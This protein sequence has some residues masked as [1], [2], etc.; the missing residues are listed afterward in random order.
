MCLWGI[1]QSHPAQSR[2]PRYRRN[3]NWA[4][5]ASMGLGSSSVGFQRY[6][7]P[8]TETRLLQN[9]HTDFRAVFSLT[10]LIYCIFRTSVRE[11][12]Y[13][14]KYFLEWMYSPRSCAV[15][16]LPLAD[17]GTISLEAFVTPSKEFS[18]HAK[19]S[20]VKLWTVNR[21]KTLPIRH[22]SYCH[23]PKSSLVFCD[24]SH[25]KSPGKHRCFASDGIS[26]VYGPSFLE[27]GREQ[28]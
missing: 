22:L 19:P 23:H 26:H 11:L 3:Q 14:R 4:N 9:S 25:L 18:R 7:I 16:M 5:R 17:V 28:R 8:N 21:A 6:S 24:G 27:C 12:Y 13:R 2:Q 1:L 15:W 10:L 20:F